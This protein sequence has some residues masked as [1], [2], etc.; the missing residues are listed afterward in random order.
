M[1]SSGT[2]ARAD[3]EYGGALA[4]VAP[5]GKLMDEGAMC[6]M[7]AEEIAAILREPDRSNLEGQRITLCLRSYTHRRP[8]QIDLSRGREE[9]ISIVA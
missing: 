4:E 8:D 6:Y 5:C 1:I 2:R 3:D 9:R 7:D